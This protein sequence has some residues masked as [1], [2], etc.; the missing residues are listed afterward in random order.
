MLLEV[1]LMTSETNRLAT[2]EDRRKLRRHRRM[3]AVSQSELAKL[4]GICR[5]TLTNIESGV[6]SQ[7]TAAEIWRLMLL[8]DEAHHAKF[9]ESEAEAVA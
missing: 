6:R 5:V 1:D 3:M 4:S 8:I 2:D 7:T 9:A